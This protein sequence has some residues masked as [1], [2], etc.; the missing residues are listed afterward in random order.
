MSIP[1]LCVAYANRI[2]MKIHN[3]TVVSVRYS[4]SGRKLSGVPFDLRC[5]TGAT[6]PGLVVDLLAYEDVV[7]NKP[8]PFINNYISFFLQY[9]L[10]KSES[11]SFPAV[12]CLGYMPM[13]DINTGRQQLF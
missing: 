2:S 1:K 12:A 9:T 13:I 11:W 6:V 7:S 10:L 4:A 5:P 3:K 8:K